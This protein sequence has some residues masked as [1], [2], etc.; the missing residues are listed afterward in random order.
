MSLDHGCICFNSTKW[1]E[2]PS[3]TICP[4]YGKGFKENFVKNELGS[5]VTITDIRKFNF[6][7]NASID[8]GFFN[9][10]TFNISEL[11]KS[12]VITTKDKYKMVD[13][14]KIKLLFDNPNGTLPA[15]FFITNNMINFGRCFTLDIPSHIKALTCNM[16]R[17]KNT[18]PH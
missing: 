11:I 5:H 8:Q 16:Y 15:R 13:D 7:I 4:R 1:A 2:I 14:Y 3:F 12:I 6:P 18:L 9:R 10:T 17:S